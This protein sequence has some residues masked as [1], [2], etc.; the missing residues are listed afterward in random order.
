M[1]ASVSVDYKPGN[2][3]TNS[4][5]AKFRTIPIESFIARWEDASRAIDSALDRLHF[6]AVTIRKASAK[7]VEYSVTNFLTDDDVVF[8]R[9]AA[10]LV[11]WR[12]PAARKSLCQQL[13]DSIAIRRKMLVLKNR[14]AKKLAVR[15]VT[16]TD[17]CPPI[18]HSQNVYSRPPL[19]ATPHGKD[20][21]IRHSKLPPSGVTKASIPDPQSPVLNNVYF[22]KPRAL[23]TVITTISTN[24]SDSFEYP[25]PPKASKG[26]TRV[27]CPYCLMPLDFRELEKRN[28]EY[29]RHHVDEDLKPYVCLFPE[30][31]QSLLF[32]ARRREWRSHME[33]THSKDWP[34][35]VHTITWYCDIDHDPPQQFEAE[36]QWRGTSIRILRES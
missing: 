18:E 20:R 6:L 30:C 23:T 11:H 28:H 13:G 34:R 25:A 32:F 21:L 31:A 8:R 12:F 22:P 33:N 15:R 7:K 5:T 36:S 27:Q 16:V 14:H 2:Q 24:Y 10:S 29:W 26:E 17:D 19:S 35:K 4:D 3:S 9:D 1:P